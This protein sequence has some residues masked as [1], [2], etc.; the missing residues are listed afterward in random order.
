ML[1]I[2][3][4]LVSTSTNILI[5]P[6]FTC[7]VSQER[8]QNVYEDKFY[9][10]KYVLFPKLK[11]LHYVSRSSDQQSTSARCSGIIPATV[12]S[13]WIFPAATASSPGSGCRHDS[14]YR[15]IEWIHGRLRSSLPNHRD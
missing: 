8:R 15:T 12:A 4:I 2:H 7:F 9:A 5:Y 14:W 6:I 13:E 11:T 10:F 1:F 3:A